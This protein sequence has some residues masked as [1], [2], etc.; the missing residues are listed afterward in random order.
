MYC[1]NCDSDLAA[2][3]ASI[4]DAN[5]EEIEL[6]AIDD[7]STDSTAGA[8][9]E[10]SLQHPD[11]VRVVSHIN[12][13]G[14]A[15]SVSDAIHAA[16]APWCYVVQVPDRIMPRELL[17]LAEKAEGCEAD[18]AAGACAFDRSGHPA[19]TDGSAPAYQT[20]SFDEGI[21]EHDA[22]PSTIYLGQG[23]APGFEG[24]LFSTELLR[25]SA[26]SLKFDS[27]TASQDVA[28]AALAAFKAERMA[29]APDTLAQIG[30]DAPKTYLSNLA[31]VAYACSARYAAEAVMSWLARNGL[32]EE[33]NAVWTAIAHSFAKRSLDIVLSS[34]EK[35]DWPQAAEMILQA[36]GGAIAGSCVLEYDE[37]RAVM[38]ALV[39]STSP[40]LLCSSR[41]PRTIACMVR[42]S[43]DV[44]AL[45]E[46]LPELSAKGVSI[47]LLADEGVEL[48]SDTEIAQILPREDSDARIRA[49]DDALRAH[50]IDTLVTFETPV[51]Y[52]HLKENVI[53]LLVARVRDVATVTVMSKQ[54]VLLKSW[55]AL[56]ATSALSVVAVFDEGAAGTAVAKA[57]GARTCKA[58]SL[59]S[60]LTLGSLHDVCLDEKF[61]AAMLLH[62]QNQDAQSTA[63]AHAQEIEAMEQRL[64]EKENEMKA[65]KERLEMELDEVQAELEESKA[66]G[67]R[68]GRPKK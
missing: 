48:D 46:L 52:G 67:F 7:G 28:V 47:S 62:A 55:E 65:Q 20:A 58:A 63:W 12:P 5:L 26:S 36:W 6:V 54:M 2:T 35:K 57:F 43:A 21:V 50:E 37:V 15:G 18:L 34:V 14:I 33:Q 38:A 42:N 40:S 59:V 56:A 49:L 61:D 44:Y 19:S 22:I 16:R 30:V 27:A 11:S 53:D 8:L 32:W 3:A 23:I 31:E 45:E 41:R 4:L 60:Q 9:A 13:A 68:F 51:E 39:L 10:L 17:V 24:K 25:H 64:A 66:K 29:C 1:R